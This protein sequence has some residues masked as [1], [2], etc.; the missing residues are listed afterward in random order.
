VKRHPIERSD[1]P[2]W[3]EVPEQENRRSL[4]TSRARRAPLRA[5]M[6]ARCRLRYARD[7]GAKRDQ[8]SR[9]LSTASIDGSF[10]V[11]RRLE[12]DEAFDRVAHPR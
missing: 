11:A 9:Q 5:H 8:P 12:P 6:I 7:V 10:V 4:D 3:V 2:D 1:R